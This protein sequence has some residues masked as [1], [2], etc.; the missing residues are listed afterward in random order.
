M[1]FRSDRGQYFKTQVINYI[2]PTWYCPNEERIGGF[3]NDGAKWIC[4][5]RLFLN[6]EEPCYIYSFGSNANFAFEDYLSRIAQCETHIFD[7]TPG[8]Q[9]KLEDINLPE[10]YHFHFEA[11]GG[12]INKEIEIAPFG[13]QK[14][15]VKPQKFQ[16]KTLDEFVTQLQTPYIDILKIDV[17]GSELNDIFSTDEDSIWTQNKIGQVFIEVHLNFNDVQS[18]VQMFKLFDFLASHGFVLFHSVR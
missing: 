11:F 9:S 4:A 5:P 6:K 16:T 7:P 3:T 2:L 8:I 12:Q 15:D 18:F 17:E 14:T 10:H 1:L 13:H